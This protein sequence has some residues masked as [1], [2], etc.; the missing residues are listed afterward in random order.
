MGGGRPLRG[1]LAAMAVEHAAR[2]I[3]RRSELPL[4]L[5]RAAR[6]WQ[7]FFRPEELEYGRKLYK[8]CAIRDIELH[9]AEALARARLEDGSEPFCVLD[10]EGDSY[11]RRGGGDLEQAALCVAAFYEIDELIGDLAASDEFLDFDAD[12]SKPP[13][14]GETPEEP[15][16]EPEVAAPAREP[17]ALE[18]A[19]ASRRRGL[20]FSTRWRTPSGARRSAYGD[21]CVQISEL[22]PPEREKLLMLAGLARKAGFKYDGE[23]HTL[24]ELSKIPPFLNNVLPKWGAHF[25]IASDA[26]V[27]LL[28]GGERRLA[29]TPEAVESGGSAGDFDVKWL[30]SVGG[31][32]IEPSELPKLIGGAGSLRIIPE[33]GIL[34]VSGGDTALVRDVE[35][36]R[37]FGFERGKIP[38]YMLLSLADFGAKLK[39]TPRLAQWKKSLENPPEASAELP[40]FLR[41]Y[42]KSGVLWAMNLF[43]HSCN[44]MIADEMGLGKTVQTLSLVNR[45]LSASP[46]GKAKF[47]VVCPASVIP[48]W[49]AEAQKFFPNVR[50]GV[51]GAKGGFAEADLWISSYTQLR[52]NRAK[53]EKM[54][55]ELAA[56]DEAQF[57]K[58]PDAKT[59]LAC[60]AISARR[61]I[62]LTGTP[63][64][65]RLMDI[66]TAFRWLMPGL[67][68]TRANFE[69]LSRG[70][71]GAVD[72]VR[73][74]ISPFVLRRMKSEVAAELPEKVQVDLYCPMSEQQKSEYAKLLARARGELESS[75]DDAR[76][77]LT[78]LSLLTRLRQAACDAALLPW[79]GPEGASEPG[80]KL[81]V[82]LDRVEELC[83]AGKK[84][85][86]FSQFAKFLDLAK[87]ALK[88]RVDEADIYT[89]TGSTRDRAAPVGSFQ[90][91]GRGCVMFVSLRAGGTGITLS[92]ADYIFLADP[93]WNPAVEE[94]AIDRA[95]RIGRRGDVFVY[96]MIAGGTVEERVR[97]LQARKRK[98]FDDLVG[99]LRDVSNREKFAQ[100]IA[101]ILK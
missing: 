23:F 71:S 96:R 19:F 77:R 40:G 27:E 31:R 79:I 68:G 57:I 58:N 72:A 39:L 1:D 69:R 33:Y 82:L 10:F 78:I 81:S 44:A 80:G 61:K 95:H 75:A 25:A 46:A 9:G 52:R 50:T 34:R 64:E 8:E 49:A 84:V 100:T 67:L 93:W 85:L 4:W 29:L 55:F 47:L 90:S 59:T 74:Q 97:N 14:G 22:L 3:Y 56:L 87:S 2:R 63:V 30:P 76:G 66:W 65:N 88:T 12:S 15:P 13:E 99:G 32:A 17:M 28:K 54:R 11:V 38:R 48:V 86:V 83:G 5:R 53:I 41:N 42:Q 26:R 101:E 51:V 62:A 18:L 35:R 37:E 70:E 94:Q 91:S 43:G 16:A 36:S 6:D 92:E 73:R 24:S 7:K 21:K 60:M 45:Y 89:L 98:L 20:V